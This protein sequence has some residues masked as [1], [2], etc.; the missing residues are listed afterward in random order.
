MPMTSTLML[1]EGSMRR[2]KCPS[3]NPSTGVTA[4]RARQAG[5]P[6]RGSWPSETGMWAGRLRPRYECRTRVTR[7]RKWF[8]V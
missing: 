1:T 3:Q 4:G 2:R 7:D 8:T 6:A 5:C